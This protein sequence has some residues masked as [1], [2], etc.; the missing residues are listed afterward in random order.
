[1]SQHA[2]GGL[3]VGLMALVVAAAV[4]VQGVST[5]RRR[6]EIADTYDRAGGPVYSAF[7]FGCAGVIGIF[8]LGL[9]ILVAL[10]PSR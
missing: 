8:G 3:F 1:M 9:L 6:V 7:Q 2:I 4:V 10:N 5:R